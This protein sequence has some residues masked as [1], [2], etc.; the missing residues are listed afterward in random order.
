MRPRILLYTGKGGVGK[1]SIAAATGALLSSKGHKTL[2]I[3]TDP[4]H[5]LGD[6]FGMEIGHSI[7]QLADNLYGQE[8]SVVQ[9]I[10]E[11]WGELKDYLRSLFLSQGLDPVSADE[12]ATLPGFEEASELLYLRNYYYDEEYDTIIMDSAPTGAA[13]QLLSF[14][15]VMTWYMDKLFPISR[16][17]ARVARPLLKPFVDIPLPEDAVFENIDLLY[18]QLTDIRK[19]LTNNDVTSI[20]LVTNPDNMSYS[21]TKRAYT[22]LLL[23]GYPVDAVI[24]NKILSDETGDFFEKMRGSQKDIITEMEN[25]FVDIKIFKAR[26]LQEEP[27]GIKKLIEL[28]KLIYGDEDPYKVFYK[29]T[30][31]KYTKNGDRYILKIKMPFAEKEKLNLFNHG[32]ELTIE[33]ANWKRVFYLPESISD[34]RPVSAEYSNGYLNVI[35]E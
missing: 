5:S 35:L 33:I 16:K 19:I 7:K 4:A 31:I 2:I 20:R 8:V 9:S 14:P 3:S 34:K 21:E 32:G 23:Y 11:H 6:A 24:I 18:R 13:L 26:L 22:Y 29:G 25:S 12:I 27:I 1:T 15:E 10:N 30:P 17:T 28:G